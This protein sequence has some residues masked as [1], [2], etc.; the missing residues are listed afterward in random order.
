MQLIN[1]DLPRYGRILSKY[2]RACGKSVAKDRTSTKRQQVS[3]ANE[4]GL[5]SQAAFLFASEPRLSFHDSFSR[6]PHTECPKDTRLK[7]SCV[8]LSALLFLSFFSSL[9][10]R[11][12]KINRSQANM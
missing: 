8:F 4:R 11:R 2:D 5:T 10:C 12:K 1:H 7:Y 6:E 9:H 3:T